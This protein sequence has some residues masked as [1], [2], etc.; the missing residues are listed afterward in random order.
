MASFGRCCD[1]TLYLSSKVVK[2]FFYNSCQIFFVGWIF[3]SLDLIPIVGTKYYLGWTNSYLS[4]FQVILTAS[5]SKKVS[6]VR[7]LAPSLLFNNEREIF[8]EINNQPSIIR[9]RKVE[10]KM[11]SQFRNLWSNTSIALSYMMYV[12]QYMKTKI[13]FNF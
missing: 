4:L 10:D 9:K 8:V 3:V 6:A 12:H 11:Q 5:G 1:I 13:C 2:S 7:I